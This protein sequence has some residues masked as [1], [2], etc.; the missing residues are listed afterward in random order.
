MIFFVFILDLFKYH[1]SVSSCLS[2]ILE[3]FV[4]YLIFF[5]WC[6][7]WSPECH[8]V[9]PCPMEWERH[10]FWCRSISYISF[11]SPVFQ[12]DHFC[13]PSSSLLT[14]PLHSLYIADLFQPS[15]GSTQELSWVQDWVATLD[16]AHLF[17]DLLRTVNP[18]P[19]CSKIL[20][21]GKL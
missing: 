11:L 15:V 4:L 8:T 20:S 2:Y 3:F 6:L 16:V 12:Y 18:A 21:P 19:P 10:T 13:S 14:F 9:R 1:E 17:P 7:R 5:L